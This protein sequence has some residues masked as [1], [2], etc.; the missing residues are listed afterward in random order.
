MKLTT[1]GSPANS[2]GGGKKWMYFRFVLGAD[3]V[4]DLLQL[5]PSW[6]VSWYWSQLSRLN[7]VSKQKSGE[8]GAWNFQCRPCQIS[9]A[10]GG[11]TGSLSS[12][13]GGGVHAGLRRRRRRRRRAPLGPR[14]TVRG[15]VRAQGCGW[16]LRWRCLSGASFCTWS[17]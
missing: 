3:F 7:S 2:S 1:V 13:S 12:G 17:V 10:R 11:Y 4:P 16:H 9:H 5:G 15:S 8:A 6:P 14:R